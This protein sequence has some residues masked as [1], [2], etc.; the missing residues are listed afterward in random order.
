M[1]ERSLHDEVGMSAPATPA[2]W[3]PALFFLLVGLTIAGFLW[4]SVLALRAGGFGAI[5]LI[6][7]LLFAITLPWFVIGF[8]NATIGLVIMRFARDPVAAVMPVAARLRGD[9]PITE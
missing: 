2:V 3:R 5:D 1:L 4:L 9:E 6:L 7:V 8:W